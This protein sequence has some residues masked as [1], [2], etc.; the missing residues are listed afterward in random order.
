M[1]WSESG[2]DKDDDEDEE[3]WYY[4]RPVSKDIEINSYALLTYTCMGKTSEGI[5]ILKWLSGQQNSL[6]GYGSTQVIFYCVL[7][8]I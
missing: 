6:G 4:R 5:P 8:N 3:F 2:N 1:Y 7:A